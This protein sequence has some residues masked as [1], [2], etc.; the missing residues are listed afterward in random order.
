MEYSSVD[1]PVT[2]VVATKPIFVANFVSRDLKSKRF[3]CSDCEYRNKR[4]SAEFIAFPEQFSLAF[5]ALNTIS[6]RQWT[7]ACKRLVDNN[8]LRSSERPESTVGFYEGKLASASLYRT[9]GMRDG[10]EGEEKEE[11]RPGFRLSEHRNYQWIRRSNQQNPRLRI[12]EDTF[13]D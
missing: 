13:F 2:A 8:S 9:V 10:G 5:R 3:G 11:G 1:G 7:D 6:R 12:S 4:R